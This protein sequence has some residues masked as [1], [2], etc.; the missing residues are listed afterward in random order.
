MTT[1][2]IHS[3][4]RAM[5]RCNYRNWHDAE[6]NIARALQNGKR[7]ED[8][9]SRER[10]FLSNEAHNNCIALAYN[11][12]CYIVNEHGACVTLY[13]LPTWFGKKEYYDGKSKIRNIRKY[14]K[15][16]QYYWE[17]HYPC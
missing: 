6:K 11:G 8:F 15:N 16:N 13:S 4:D 2:T 5:E 14:S 12:F 10:K 9:T 3:I 1:T 17:P 7:A